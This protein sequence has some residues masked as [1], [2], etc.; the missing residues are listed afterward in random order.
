MA[1]TSYLHSI[2]NYSLGQHTYFMHYSLAI[3]TSSPPS[4]NH[5]FLNAHPRTHT[6]AHSYIFRFQHKHIPLFPYSK[7]ISSNLWA[8]V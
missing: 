6:H 4:I 5:F 3:H 8:M 2:I 1:L 7:E